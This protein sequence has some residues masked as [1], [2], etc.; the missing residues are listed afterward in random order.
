MRLS[1]GVGV[2]VGVPLGLLVGDAVGVLLGEA[3]GVP[4]GVA[5]GVALGEAEGD[6]LGVELGVPLGLRVGVGVGLAVLLVVGDGVGVLVAE[7]VRPGRP[8]HR[9]TKPPRVRHQLFNGRPPP[10]PRL[11]TIPLRLG[12]RPTP[13]PPWIACD[14]RPPGTGGGGTW[15]VGGW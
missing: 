15:R 5:L 4:V 2:G 9:N 14:R 8:G 13:L 10:W 1:V 3:E 6:A 11:H 12:S 7:E